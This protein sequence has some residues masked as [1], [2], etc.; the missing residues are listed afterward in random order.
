MMI[1]ILLKDLGKIVELKLGI[2]YGDMD[3][4]VELER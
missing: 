1:L 4:N 3:N 2:I